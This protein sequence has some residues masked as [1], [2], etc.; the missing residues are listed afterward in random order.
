MKCHLLQ[1]CLNRNKTHSDLQR[2]SL[3]ERPFRGSPGVGG[4]DLDGVLCARVE[5]ADVEGRLVRRDVQHHR[6]V[7]GVVNLGYKSRE[8]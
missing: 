3:E 2:E 1:E 5:A 6:V 7:G 4:V 8:R